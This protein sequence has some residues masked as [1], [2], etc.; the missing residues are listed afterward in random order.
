M[1]T[2]KLKDEVKLADLKDLGFTFL[3]DKKNGRYLW[4][5]EI[6]PYDRI[7]VYKNK[8]V[9]YPRWYPHEKKILQFLNNLPKWADEEVNKSS[10]NAVKVMVSPKGEIRTFDWEYFL[11]THKDSE[12]IEAWYDK[13]KH[14]IT[15][16]YLRPNESYVQLL[17]SIAQLD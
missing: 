7:W 4:A 13:Y 11:E 6:Q 9:Y 1:I 17:T 8:A 10:I 12:N 16:L 14:W 2:L 5:Y 15:D 3:H